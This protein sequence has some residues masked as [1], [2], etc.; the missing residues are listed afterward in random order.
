MLKSNMENLQEYSACS[1]KYADKDASCGLN[2][3]ML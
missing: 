1:K 3:P 2:L